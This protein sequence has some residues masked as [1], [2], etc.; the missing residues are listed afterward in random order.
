MAEKGSKQSVIMGIDPGTAIT[1][2][3]I[4]AVKRKEPKLIE[5]G[6]IETC[7]TKC[8]VDRLK[9]IAQDLEKLIQNLLLLF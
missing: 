9:E 4:I 5:Y 1:G 7:K 6:C 8:N 2:W 3:G